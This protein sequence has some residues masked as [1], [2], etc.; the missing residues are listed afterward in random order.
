MSDLKIPEYIAIDGPIGVGKTSLARRLAQDLNGQLI[1]E[2][3][4][5]NPFIE[6]FYQDPEKMALP[7]QLCFLFQRTKLL[8]NIPQSDLFH[9]CRIVD[10]ILDKDVLFAEATL[11]ADELDLYKQVYSNMTIDVPKP[12]LVVYLQAPTDV[13]VQ[14]IRQRNKDSDT[15]IQSDYLRKIADAYANYFHYF[16]ECPLLIVNAS[17]LD[18]V[19][20]ETD[21]QQLKS[22]ILD[23]QPGKHY[24]NPIPFAS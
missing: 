1:L 16:N 20:N 12:D 18:I 10:F 23:V 24:F 21:Y 17:G 11:N 2:Q 6:K 9:S 15:L 3:P 5:D 8:Q 19:N 7:T 14:R 4:D 13:L 22:R